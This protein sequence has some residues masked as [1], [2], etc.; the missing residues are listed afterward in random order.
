MKT[1]SLTMALA[2]LVGAFMWGCQ[3]QGSGPV[4]PD[5]VAPLFRPTCNENPGCSKD[6]AGGTKGGDKSTVSVELSGGMVTTTGPQL[7]QL[8]GK[9]NAK[10]LSL[11]GTAS[12]ELKLLNTRNATL[13]EN[14]VWEGAF[15]GDFETAQDMLNLI[16]D[17][18]QS[19]HIGVNIDKEAVA[20][21]VESLKQLI[22]S[23]WKEDDSKL[24]PSGNT[25]SFGAIAGND[26]KGAFALLD[27]S[28]IGPAIPPKVFAEA[29]FGG[30]PDVTKYTFQADFGIMWI[31]QLG[32][33]GL[34]VC[35][36][37]DEVVVI[38]DLTP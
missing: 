37:R 22:N 23:P 11:G 8:S 21:G 16:V 26:N 32:F 1:Q 28:P 24:S 35:H 6:K 10:A 20:D 34:L 7:V 4:A 5:G 3:D 9:N 13:A 30:D 18:P 19:R 25:I 27:K 12:Y 31:R 29:N 17:D 33:D 38:V 15:D 2:F 36:N 14:C